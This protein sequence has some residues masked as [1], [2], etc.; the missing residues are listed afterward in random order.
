MLEEVQRTHHQY[1]CDEIKKAKR[2][3]K[4]K[5]VKTPQSD[6]NLGEV[7]EVALFLSDYGAQLAR[8][9]CCSRRTTKKNGGRDEDA[10]TSAD[11]RK[12]MDGGNPKK[13]E[14]DKSGGQN[15]NEE[16]SKNIEVCGRAGNSGTAKDRKRS[17]SNSHVDFR[18]KRMRSRE[19]C[20][21]K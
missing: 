14:A 6:E 12:L 17:L 4:V 11:Q 20:E 9:Q 10:T 21:W 8:R 2:R 18:W 19:N 3:R 7:R 16:R 15:G 5:E 13:V 1:V